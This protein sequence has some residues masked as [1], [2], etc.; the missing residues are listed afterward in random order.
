ME[1]ACKKLSTKKIIVKLKKLM[2]L[3]A[4]KNNC[5]YRIMVYIPLK[6]YNDTNYF[7]SYHQL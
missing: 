4:F 7:Q 1:K 3:I 5:D 2:C 6:N